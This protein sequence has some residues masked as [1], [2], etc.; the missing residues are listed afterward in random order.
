MARKI[1][2]PVRKIQA[3][4]DAA[5]PWLQG[6]MDYREGLELRLVAEKGSLLHLSVGGTG[7]YIEATIRHENLSDL[8]EPLFLDMDYL[9]R[10]KFTEDTMQVLIP[11]KGKGAGDLRVQFKGPNVSFKIP[12][13][14]G[15]KWVLHQQSNPPTL[16]E[17]P[18]YVLPKEFLEDYYTRLVLPNS[19]GDAEARAFQIRTVEDKIRIYSN[20]DFGAFCH[21]FGNLEH[22]FPIN[23]AMGLKVLHEFLLPYKGIRKSEDITLMT[24]Q[25]DNNQVYGS[26]DFNDSAFV[27]LL[28]IQPLHAKPIQDVPK[29]LADSRKGIDWCLEFDTREISR[30]VDRATSFYQ[31]ANFR[32]NPLSFSIVGQQYTVSTTLSSSDMSVNGTALTQA[33]QVARA[34][35]QAG[36]FADYLSCLDSDQQMSMELLRNSAILFQQRDGV[37]L[38][39]WMPISE[40]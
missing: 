18:G 23:G 24:L 16:S 9:V 10:Y 3:F 30:N 22:L 20:D 31:K 1:E 32:E 2:L 5:V 14:T 40:R 28:W 15:D 17:L 6:S 26:I 33:P 39:Y 7:H 8:A 19:F 21:T 27:S 4:L 29:I 25:A 13:R 11:D 36:C 34:K 37:E 12:V 35:F 38:V